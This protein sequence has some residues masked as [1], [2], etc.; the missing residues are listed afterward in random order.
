[1]R[2]ST[3]KHGGHGGMHTEETKKLLIDHW[4]PFIARGVSTLSKAK[5]AIACLPPLFRSGRDA[6]CSYLMHLYFFADFARSFCALCACPDVSVVKPVGARPIYTHPCKP[7]HRSLLTNC[8]LNEQWAINSYWGVK[9]E[10]MREWT[11]PT[12][13][14]NPQM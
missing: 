5:V 9:N 13:T 1:M 7:G 8:S 4:S 2:T 12:H 14:N 10:G 11:S 6:E 3:F